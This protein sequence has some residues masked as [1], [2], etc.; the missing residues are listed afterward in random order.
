MIDAGAVVGIAVAGVRSVDP[1]LMGATRRT[2]HAMILRVGIRLAA[3]GAGLGL[4]G[5]VALSQ[6]ISGLLFNVEPIDPPTYAAIGVVL[7]AT[8]IAACWLPARRASSL[9]P[10]IATRSD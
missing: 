2:I 10:L 6:V 4:I 3:I 5:A 8:V 1:G 7:S 9:S